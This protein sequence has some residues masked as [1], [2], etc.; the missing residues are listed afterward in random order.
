MLMKNVSLLLANPRDLNFQ[1]NTSPERNAGI[2][3]KKGMH[4]PLEG[5]ELLQL[6]MQFYVLGHE[7]RDPQAELLRIELMKTGRT[8]YDGLHT[9]SY[10]F[11]SAH[12]FILS[13]CTGL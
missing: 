2:A 7:I 13:R 3:E 10:I 1:R 6:T 5:R 11:P 4:F 9:T 12:S 8:L